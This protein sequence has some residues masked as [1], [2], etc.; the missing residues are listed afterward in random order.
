MGSERKISC[1]LWGINRKAQ[2]EHYLV[3]S[4]LRPAARNAALASSSVSATP[5][6]GPCE[7][8]PRKKEPRRG[9]AQVG[10]RRGSVPRSRLRSRAR[11]CPICARVDGPDKRACGQP[12]SAGYASHAARNAALASSR[13]SATPP[14]G[15]GRLACDKPEGLAAASFWPGRQFRRNHRDDRPCF[16]E[17]RSAQLHRRQ[18]F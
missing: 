5:P 7:G 15:P 16:T 6:F 1:P 17:T 10:S 4:R 18:L 2:V 3:R 13:L 9:F 12:S 11:R 14:L 8:A